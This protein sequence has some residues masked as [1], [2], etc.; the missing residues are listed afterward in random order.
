MRSCREQGC[1]MEWWHRSS[2][3]ES[4][5]AFILGLLAK[6]TYVMKSYKSF[7]LMQVSF[8]SSFECNGPYPL[9]EKAHDSVQKLRMSFLVPN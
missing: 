6:L 5:A 4:D 1:L 3:K 7:F 8:Q 9:S 2:H